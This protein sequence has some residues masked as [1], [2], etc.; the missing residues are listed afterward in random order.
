MRKLYLFMFIMV[1]LIAVCGCGNADTIK[2]EKIEFSDT[3]LE[4]AADSKVELSYS[5]QPEN[6]NEVLIWESSD[7]SIAE[8]DNNGVVKGVKKGKCN[9]TVYTDNPKKKRGQVKIEVKKY[10]V[11][12]T[13]AS[14]LEILFT[15]TT[16]QYD[17]L[18]WE[19]K[20]G[21]A[22]ILNLPKVVEFD[23]FGLCEIPMAINALKAGTD[24]LTIKAGKKTIKEIS[25]FISPDTYF[26]SAELF[27]EEGLLLQRNEIEEKGDIIFNWQMF[28]FSSVASRETWKED[29]AYIEQVRISVF[30]DE[31]PIWTVVEGLRNPLASPGISV[32]LAGTDDDPDI[33]VFISEYGL[34]KIDLLTGKSRFPISAQDCPCGS[35]SVQAVDYDKGIIYLAGEG[36]PNLVAVDKDGQVLW[37]EKILNNE[38]DTIKNIVLATDNI[39][40]ELSDGDNMK[41]SFEGTI[42]D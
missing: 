21:C 29:D 12:F 26:P 30:V 22:C 10:D 37:V 3:A 28:N 25:V 9:I 31:S 39:E 34:Q 4:M 32:F 20:N 35:G 17:S 19:S 7:P 6:A 13:N 41:V 15:V 24:I 11:V 16:G 33:Y 2:L 42:L 40:V 36:S 23:V 18:S 5:L 1:V 27:S 14:I 8:V 38:K